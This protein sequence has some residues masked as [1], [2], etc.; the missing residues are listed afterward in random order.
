MAG[1][2]GQLRL[3]WTDNHRL[4]P[5]SQPQADSGIV[6]T[7]DQL[8]QQENNVERRDRTSEHSTSKVWQNTTNQGE[9]NSALSRTGRRKADSAAPLELN[10]S[11]LGTEGTRGPRPGWPRARCAALQ[12]KPG[13]LHRIWQ[14]P[15]EARSSSR[16]WGG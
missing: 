16:A 5:E 8:T 7:Q 13:S 3:R 4:Q 15:P 6:L 11:T 9:E 10:G 1:S 12:V 14:E 2:R